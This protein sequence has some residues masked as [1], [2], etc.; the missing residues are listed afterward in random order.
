MI[1][2]NRKITPLILAVMISLQS[3]NSFG[4]DAFTGKQ[5]DTVQPALTQV[6]SGSPDN[7][8]QTAVAYL[9]PTIHWGSDVP[10]TLVAGILG[11]EGLQWVDNRTDATFLINSPGDN[12][13]G[14]VEFQEVMQV[15]A[16]VAPFPTV[17]DGVSMLNLQ[18]FWRGEDSVEFTTLMMSPETL[19]VLSGVWGAPQMEKIE[20]VSNEDAFGYWKDMNTWGILRF[21]ELNPRWKVVTLDEVSPLDPNQ[22]LE[23]YPLAFTYRLC[24]KPGSEATWENYATQLRLPQTNRELDKMTTLVTTGVTALVRATAYKMEVKGVTYPA[25]DIRDWLRQADITHISNE[26]AFIEGCPMPKENESSLT[27]CSDPKYIA[28]LEDVGADVIELTGNHLND[29]PMSSVDLSLDLYTE[30]GWQYFGGGKD[31]EDSRSPALFEHNGNQIAFIGCNEPGPD[32]AF[33]TETRGGSAPCDGYAWMIDT[34]HQL[35]QDGYQVVANV[36][37]HEN[38]S[39]YAG[40]FLTAALRP[41]ADAGAVIVQGSQAHTPKE[42]EFRQDAFIHFGLGNL[43][44]DQMS[45]IENGKLMDATQKEFIDRYTFY[46]NRLISIELLTAMLEDYA[47]PRPMTLEEREVLLEQVFSI[48]NWE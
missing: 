34:I 47:K 39:Y 2:K 16:L 21:E 9:E 7:A 45:Y 43:F 46:N 38:Y 15:Y 37:Y 25:I 23:N 30:R 8:T 36:Q 41:L 6:T 12:R 27:F 20:I 10:Q 17:T 22:T 33:A 32:F 24:G 11:I 14:D 18:S 40:E 1:N 31:L 28:L 29:W 4:G 3:C 44:F 48:S 35:K 5:A 42:M 19:A 26:V 13:V